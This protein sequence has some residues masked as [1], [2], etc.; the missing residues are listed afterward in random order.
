M[1]PTFRYC[2]EISLSAALEAVVRWCEQQSECSAA[3][4]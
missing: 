3:E 4:V 2:T 1:S